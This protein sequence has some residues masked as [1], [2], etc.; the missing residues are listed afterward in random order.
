MK[1]KNL[2]TKEHFDRDYGNRDWRWYQS[3]VAEGIKYGVPGKW[4]DFGAGLGLF[5]ECATRFGIDCVGLEGS[6]HAVQAAKERFSNIDMRQHFLEE[7][8]SFENN[9]ISMI[10]CNQIIEHVPPDVVKFML[11]ESFR[12]LRPGGI[13]FVS[14]PCWYNKKQRED[15]T[16]INLYT[17]SLLK[18][19]VEK[20]GFVLKSCSNSPRMILGNFRVAKYVMRLIFRIFPLDFLSATADCIAIK[21][22]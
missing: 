3:L 9:S 16:H 20:A 22:E 19:E 10:M 2:Y 8:L 4:L 5:V 17:P 6:E 11:K 13:I 15:E 14:S 21:T 1:G 12:V 7:R 18:K